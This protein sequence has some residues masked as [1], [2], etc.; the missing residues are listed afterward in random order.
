MFKAIKLYV[1]HGVTI[2]IRIQDAGVVPIHQT[3]WSVEEDGFY[4]SEDKNTGRSCR[5]YSAIDITADVPKG[6]YIDRD[7][8]AAI[9]LAAFKK[10]LFIS[11]NEQVG[12]AS[13]MVLKGN[14]HYYVEK[15]CP[16]THEISP[17]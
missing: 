13:V 8:N 6:T 1:S 10:G 15:R 14:G 17:I 7:C 2:I 5:I 12:C 16:I 9:V 11:F 3:I 4:M